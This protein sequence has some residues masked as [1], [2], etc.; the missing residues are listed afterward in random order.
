MAE[1]LPFAP[2]TVGSY[3][4]TTFAEYAREAREEL[5]YA[6]DCAER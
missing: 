3:L 2:A 4:E 1:L 6:A 5:P